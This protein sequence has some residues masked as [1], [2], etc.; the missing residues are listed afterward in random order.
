MSL[1]AQVIPSSHGLPIAWWVFWWAL[2]LVSTV[3]FFWWWFYR[4][5]QR[6]RK[7]QQELDREQEPQ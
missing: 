7:M 6:D 3:G 2:L 5:V 4:A 1:L